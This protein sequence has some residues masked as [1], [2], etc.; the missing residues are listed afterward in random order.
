MKKTLLI[1]I[2]FV[3][4]VGCQRPANTAAGFT[5]EEAAALVGHRVECMK[6]PLEF[7]PIATGKSGQTIRLSA[8]MKGEVV[9]M[10]ERPQGNFGVIVRWDLPNKEGGPWTSWISRYSSRAIK[11]LGTPNP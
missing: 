4:V 9:S 10:D 6:T 11:V 3:G 7:I 1:A 2:A 8:G 5:R